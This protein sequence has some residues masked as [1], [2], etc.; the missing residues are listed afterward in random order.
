MLQ[1]IRPAALF[2]FFSAAD[3]APCMLPTATESQ[4][5]PVS[6]TKRAASSGSVNPRPVAN[7]SS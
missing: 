4:S 3:I 6:R 5:T 2:W 1:A 7:S